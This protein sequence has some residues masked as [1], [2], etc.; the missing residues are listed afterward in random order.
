L[1]RSKTMAYCSAKGVPE[2]EIGSPGG[3]EVVVHLLVILL[4]F[5][6]FR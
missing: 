4:V 1:P 2:V 3:N 5:V 6:L